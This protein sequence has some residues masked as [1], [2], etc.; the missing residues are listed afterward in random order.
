MTNAIRDEN[1]VPVA[2]GVDSTDST[3]TLPFKIDPATGKLLVDGGGGG[4]G[5]TS[6]N[7]LTGAVILAAGTNITLTPVGNTITI[8]ASGSP[9]GATTQAQFNNAGAFDGDA[10]FTYDDTNRMVITGGGTITGYTPSSTTDSI[11]AVKSTT[12]FFGG[13]SSQ[14]T[15]AGT[16]ASN[17]IIAYDDT[18]INY[19]D[20]G[21]ASSGNTDANFTSGGAS[22]TYIYGYG[23]LMTIGTATAGKSLQFITGGTLTANIRMTI[24]GNGLITH[25]TSDTTSTQFTGTY[26]SVT[27]GIGHLITANALTSGSGFSVT[28]SSSAG[29]TGLKGI[30]VALTGA[31]NGSTQTTYA[32][33]FSNIR[34]G[35]TSNS[36]GVYA[37]TNG[38]SLITDIPLEYAGH[39][40]G[41]IKFGNRSSTEAAMWLNSVTPSSTNY[42]F[43]L[44]ST[45]VQ[46]NGTLQIR[47][48]ASN[49]G[50]WNSTGISIDANNNLPTGGQRFMVR[51]DPTASANYGQINLGNQGNWAGG[52]TTPFAGSSSG[53]G[54]ATNYAS[55][56]T[57]NFAD[58][59]ITGTSYFSVSAIKTTLNNRMLE[60]QGADVASAGDL[61]LGT[62]GN[63]FEITGTTTINAIT[64]TNWQLGAKV[65]LIF[66]STP[67]VKHNTSGGANTAVILLAGAADF[68][69]TAGDTL[70]L[71]YSEQG[72]TN[73]WREIGRAVI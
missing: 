72:G 61:T 57:G 26:N 68:S 73:A 45:G 24:D 17:D 4:G 1:F 60:K 9:G 64:T 12:S 11:F 8:S 35:T 40:G 13:L 28:S 20:V 16:T 55:G 19:I 67:T 62:D 10:F 49:I 43:S 65:T 63:T 22:T 48:G 54:F 70:T 6:L 44:T 27:T 58:F 36:I 14:N 7:T 56:Y 5:V 69:A 51:Y 15:S 38:A 59:Q 23:Q 29:V 30:N 31:N 42:S 32:G 2:L 3:L 25:T 53:T 46:F 52:G 41:G 47:S 21:I 37:T 34:T 39:Q 18:G 33:Y 50:G 71:C 66:A